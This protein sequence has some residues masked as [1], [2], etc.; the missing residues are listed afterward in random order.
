VAK[1]WGEFADHVVTLLRDTDERRA[2]ETQAR[3]F[4]QRM[5]SVDSAFAEL[6]AA[7]HAGRPRVSGS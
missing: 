3:I 1:D 2:L 5:F 6:D 4:A 7:L